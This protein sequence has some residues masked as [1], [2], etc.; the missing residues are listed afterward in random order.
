[1]TLTREQHATMTA[2][3]KGQGHTLWPM[4]RRALLRV[5]YIEAIGPVIEPSDARRARVPVRPYGLTDAGRKVLAE[6][7]GE[8]EPKKL[9]PPAFKTLI[10]SKETE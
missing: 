10:F 9:R 6:Y 8:P 3:L 5:G 7:Q 1:M 4:M 2:M